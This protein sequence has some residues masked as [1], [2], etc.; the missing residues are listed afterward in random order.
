MDLEDFKILIHELFNKDPDIVP[1]ETPLIIL[2]RK[3]AV[4]MD[5]SGKDT[6]HTIHIDR[7]VQFMINGEKCKMYKI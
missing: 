3:S 7:K 5:K 2:D 6:K 4:Y 1:K